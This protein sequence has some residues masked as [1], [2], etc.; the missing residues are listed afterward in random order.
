MSPVQ[1]KVHETPFAYVWRLRLVVS[2]PKGSRGTEKQTRKYSEADCEPFN[3]SAA[4][5]EFALFLLPISIIHYLPN[6]FFG[7]LL[8]LFGVEILADWLIHSYKKAG[9]RRLSYARYASLPTLLLSV[10]HR[11]HTEGDGTGKWSLCGHAGVACGVCAPLGDLCG[12][13]ADRPGARNPHRH[14]HGCAVF[15]VLI[16]SGKQTL[17]EASA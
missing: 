14:H 6:F 15:R 12:D 16:C 7:S 2:L 9:F 8:M 17:H 4:G 11:R 1:K 3:G 10:A 13:H 5:V